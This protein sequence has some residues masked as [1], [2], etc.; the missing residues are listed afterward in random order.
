MILVKFGPIR[1]HCLDVIVMLV[2]FNWSAM[3]ILNFAK[4]HL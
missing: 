3:G 1:I 4:F 2:N